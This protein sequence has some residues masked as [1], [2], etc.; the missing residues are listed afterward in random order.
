MSRMLIL[1][2][3]E[4]YMRKRDCQKVSQ[5]IAERIKV[6][7]LPNTPRIR[8]LK[9][10]LMLHLLD[11]AKGKRFPNVSQLLVVSGNLHLLVIVKRKLNQTLALT[12]DYHLL[13]CRDQGHVKKLWSFVVVQK[14]QKA[15]QT[16]E[17]S[18]NLLRVVI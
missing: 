6:V 8:E 15:V 7:H 18:S 2:L 12:L 1:H 14:R 17:M 5:S 13:R 10:I 16:V 3:L 11:V 9:L 4:M